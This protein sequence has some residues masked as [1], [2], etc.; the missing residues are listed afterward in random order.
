M[1][2]SFPFRFKVSVECMTY[3]Q[4][5]FIKDAM[6][7][8]CMQQTT[9]PFICFI[10]D[11]A[12]T[13]GEPEVISHYMELHFLLEGNEYYTEDNDDY[14]LVI[15]RH[16]QNTNCYFA[17]FYLK[18]NHY[19]I[20]KDKNHY[21]K[22]WTDVK[23]VALCEGDDYWT[24]SRKLQTQV[25]Y[26]EGHNDCNIAFNYVNVVDSNGL[27]LDK[28]IPPNDIIDKVIISLNDLIDLEFKRGIWAFH[29]S[30]IVFRKEIEDTFL[31]LKS[32]IFRTIHCGDLPLELTCLLSGNGYLVHEA[33]GCYRSGVGVFST[34]RTHFENVIFQIEIIDSFLNFDTYTNYRYSKAINVR[35]KGMYQ[36]ILQDLVYDTAFYNGKYFRHIMKCDNK[37]NILFQFVRLRYITYYISSVR[38]FWG[39]KISKIWRR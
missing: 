19:S 13:D 37:W 26:L 32:T 20:N 28:T 25:E 6:N 9:F 35:I 8:F 39:K 27:W 7:G 23:Y 30:S 17:C 38:I 2:A 5:D 33:F 29:T 15:A 14:H 4:S 24:N 11:D 22:R 34:N 16:R 18:Y 1:S 12:S 3:N 10:L 36:Y 31:K 21:L